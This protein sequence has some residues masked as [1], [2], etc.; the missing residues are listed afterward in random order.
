MLKNQK[1]LAVT[2]HPW[3]KVGLSSMKKKKYAGPPTSLGLPWCLS[4]KEF[5]CQCRRWGFSLW[6]RKIPWRRKWQP[7]PVFWPGKFHGWRSLA[8]YS[9]WGHKEWASTQRPNSL[10]HAFSAQLCKGWFHQIS[11]LKY[12]VLDLCSE[13][14]IT[15]GSL[16][17]EELTPLLLWREVVK[18]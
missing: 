17:G 1:S 2:P 6:V 5:A 8:G 11:Y 15:W 18:L 7:T 14:S 9:P 13:W 3:N 4:G 12:L 10:Q 16:D